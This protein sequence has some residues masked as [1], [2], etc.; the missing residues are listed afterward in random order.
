MG[1]LPLAPRSTYLA[2]IE[3]ADTGRSSVVP[4]GTHAHAADK[5][6][7]PSASWL[8][9]QLTDKDAVQELIDGIEYEPLQVRVVSTAVNRTGRGASRGPELIEPIDDRGDRPL[10]LLPA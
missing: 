2:L 7:R 1:C 8:D 5:A 9:P 3:N 6:R 4:P 10:Q